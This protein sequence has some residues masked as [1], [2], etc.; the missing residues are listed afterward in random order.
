M[1]IGGGA[2]H[3]PKVDE[4]EHRFARERYLGAG[5]PVEILEQ[6]PRARVLYVPREHPQ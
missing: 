4:R 2:D 5:E 6:Q 3:D 1:P